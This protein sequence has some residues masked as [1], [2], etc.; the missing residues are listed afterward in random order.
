MDASREAEVE[1]NIDRFRLPAII[2]KGKQP[3]L[4][5]AHSDRSHF[6]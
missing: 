1:G 2:G 5:L 3:K 6:G 4:R